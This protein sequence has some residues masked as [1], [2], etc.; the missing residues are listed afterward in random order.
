MKRRGRTVKVIACEP[1]TKHVA[2]LRLACERAGY[3]KDE[4]TILQ[5]RVG[6]SKSSEIVTLN[7]ILVN[8]PADE[9][10]AIKID[11]E[12]AELEVL[13]GAKSLQSKH[14][15]PHRG[16]PS[17]FLECNRASEMLPYVGYL[18]L[19]SRSHYPFWDMKNEINRIGGWC[20]DLA[21]D[22]EALLW[23]A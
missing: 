23:Q 21:V 9:V 19:I 20:P 5:N 12:G 8:R 6:H 18:D 11:V 3:T 4:V 17:R 1:D 7:D 14:A 22:L 10:R 13:A 15:S 2:Q 16:A